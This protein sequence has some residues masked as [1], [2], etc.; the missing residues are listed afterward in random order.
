MGKLTGR[1]IAIGGAPGSQ[2]HWICL[3]KL[4]AVIHHSTQLFS[5]NH[6]ITKTNQL[7]RRVFIDFT[8]LLFRVSDALTREAGHYA[9]IDTK[10][11]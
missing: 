8:M 5:S 2:F 11:V 3:R 9:I 4:I 1:S 6:I 10:K 7:K